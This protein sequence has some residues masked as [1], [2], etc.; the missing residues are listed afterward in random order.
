M[1]FKYGFTTTGKDYDGKMELIFTD[2]PYQDVAFIMDGMK[3]ADEEN[4]DGTINMSFDYEV[5]NEKEV[6]ESFG[7][8][9][10]ELI[11]YILEEQVKN[12]DVIYKG[13]TG[14]TEV[15]AN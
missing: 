14:E 4:D 12:K 13:G 10:G 5:T 2:G 1:T 9:L 15:V 3:F 8:T 6:D 11:Y 7:P